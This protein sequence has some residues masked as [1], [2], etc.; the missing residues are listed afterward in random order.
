MELRIC[1]AST[2][3]ILFW[4]LSS[5]KVV[6]KFYKSEIWILKGT[7]FFFSHELDFF[8]PTNSIFLGYNKTGRLPWYEMKRKSLSPSSMA[9]PASIA[10]IDD[11]KTNPTNQWLIGFFNRIMMACDLCEKKANIKQTKWKWASTAKR[12]LLYENWRRQN[13]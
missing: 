13:C 8:S 6:I 7:Q 1:L 3:R 2:F 12:S 4:L 10:M 11:T 9:S 5:S